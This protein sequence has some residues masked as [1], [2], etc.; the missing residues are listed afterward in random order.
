MAQNV[1]PQFRI[2]D[3]RRSTRFYVDGLGF[4]IDWEHRFKPGFPVFMQLTRA[5]QSIFLTEHAGDCQ[6]GGAAYFVVADVDACHKE[7]MRRG[8]V[9]TNPPAD[10]PWGP[11]EMVVTDPD[12][13][14]LRFAGPIGSAVSDVVSSNDFKTHVTA[15][16]SVRDWARAVD[17][18]K[19]AFGAIELFRVPGG[20]VGQLSVSGAQFWVAEESAPN[21]N[22]S[23]ESLGG[24]SVRMLLIVEDPAA[25]CKQAIAAGATPVSPVVDAHGWRLGRIV[26]PFGHHWE[27]ARPLA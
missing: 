18:Y 25:V 2:T 20:G 16:L 24:C 26:D 21:L 15:T 14:R 4:K 11:R 1:T 19:E 13:N 23:P 17:F 3:A 5:G 8:I 7:F 27:V 9:P 10:M 22:F 6:I 12:G